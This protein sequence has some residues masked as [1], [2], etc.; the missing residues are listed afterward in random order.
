MWA[1]H[2]I[3]WIEQIEKGTVIFYEELLGKNAIR[4]LERF[5]KAMEFKNEMD[6]ERAR[7]ALAHRDRADYK[8]KNKT[9]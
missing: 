1:D 6:P 5:W 9:L 2:A 4:E 7:C 8:R 3:R